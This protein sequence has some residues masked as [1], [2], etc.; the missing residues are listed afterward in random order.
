[1]GPLL[2]LLGPALLGRA[3]LKPALRCT[4]RLGWRRRSGFE[5]FGDMGSSVFL[6][7][8]TAE[9][10]PASLELALLRPGSGS[11]GGPVLLA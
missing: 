3:Q 9:P 2:A 8:S 6:V 4:F 11:L 1:V 5:K 10:G 7:T